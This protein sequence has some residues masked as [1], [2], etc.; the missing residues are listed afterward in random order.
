MSTGTRALQKERKMMMNILKKISAALLA[1]LLALGCCVQSIPAEAVAQTSAHVFFKAASVGGT[2]QSAKKAQPAAQKALSLQAERD[3]LSARLQTVYDM[4]YQK[5]KRFEAFTADLCAV[6]ISF[7]EFKRVMDAME[8]DHPE[9]WLYVNWD[10]SRHTETFRGGVRFIDVFYRCNWLPESKGFSAKTMQDYLRRI[11]RACDA[12]IAAM[13]ARLDAAQQYLYLG[14]A[15]CDRAA[16]EDRS[17]CVPD[18]DWSYCFANGVLLGTGGVCQAYT[19]AYQWLCHRAGLPCAAVKSY[20]Q[21]H[22]WNIVCLEDGASYHV[23][24]TW[25]DE[26]SAADFDDGWFLLTQAQIEA[27][28]APEAGEFVATGK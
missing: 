28:H 3:R 13:P 8:Y 27:D 11:D 26:G 2:V 12:I 15:I 23:D 18:T 9:C 25:C 14:K 20:T 5:C 17:E 24:L 16:Y 1:G 10:A 19:M 6:K 4:F 7:E 21:E 22:I